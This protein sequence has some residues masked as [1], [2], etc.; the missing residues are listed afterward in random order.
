M[1]WRG[2]LLIFLIVTCFYWKL[3]LSRQFT[4]LE[5]L[6]QA[7]QVLPWLDLDVW[8][9][10]HGSIP[11]WTPY[12][13]DGQSLIGQVQPGVVSPFTY[14]LALAPTKNGHIQIPWVHL[15]FVLIHLVGAW[16]AYA[17]LRDL[18]LRESAAVLGA[19][20]YGTMGFYGNTD[21]P[22]FLAAAI[23]APLVFLFI[24]RA[25]RGQAPLASSCMAGFFTGMSWL[26]G[27]PVRPS[28]VP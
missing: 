26:S 4:F 27:H 23:W 6:D 8:A 28:H 14:I 17:L 21:W 19:V 22:Q 5:S 10:Q 1:R 16:F 7:D 2:P 18:K 20:L 11:L 12:E 3:T 15:W 24:L 13:F 9:I 25:G